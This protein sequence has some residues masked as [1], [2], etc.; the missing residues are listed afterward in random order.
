ME[1][2]RRAAARA[3]L[4]PSVH[5]T[6][7]WRLELHPGRLDIYADFN[8]RLAVLD[9]SGRQLVISC[10]C[11]VMNAR[12]SLAGSG[13]DVDVVRTASLARTDLMASLS[14]TG[15]PADATLGALDV[16]MESRVTNRRRFNG[17]PVP[18]QMLSVLTGAASDE[19]ASLAVIRN[20]TDRLAAVALSRHADY[21]ENHNS[22]YRSE[23]DA[24]TTADRQ[25]TD[26]VPNW[27][28]PPVGDFAP[29][30]IPIRDFDTRG[31]AALPVYAESAEDGTLAVLLTEQDSPDQWL[32][33]G[34]ALERIL[35]E[36]TRGGYVASPHTQVIEVPVTRAQLRH[37]LG[38]T[39][40]PHIL[41]RI[42]HAVA[43]QAVPRRPLEDVLSEFP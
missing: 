30:Q 26:G 6:Q 15:P 13:F 35:L 7:P 43:T 14:V 8:R 20:E 32:R 18:E 19:Q 16:V 41:L 25:R 10:G 3:T 36:I 31:Y 17:G 40:Y 33:A 28:V 1:A 2:L 23:L 9:P 34:E 5:N 38:L 4:A 39:G 11:A 12:V 37:D 42:G 29:D 22:A 27:A 21:V 24:W